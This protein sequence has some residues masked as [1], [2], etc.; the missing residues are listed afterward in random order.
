MVRMPEPKSANSER[1][2]PAAAVIVAAGQ[3]V[4]FGAAGPRK[5]YRLVLGIP[6]LEWAIRPFLDHPA[7]HQVVVVLPSAD[8][9]DPPEW[10][11][12]LPVNRVAGGERRSDSVRLGLDALDP[13]HERVL[14]HDGARPF[15]TAELIDRL[16][17]SISG[18]EAV[19]PGLRSTDT[20]KEV[21][22]DGIVRATV[23]RD[24]FWSV[25]TP[26]VFPLKTLRLLHERAL[27]AGV[28]TSDDAGLL[29]SNGHVVR[30][31]EGDPR[32]MKVTV[33]A[34]I[35]LAEQ[36]ARQLPSPRDGRPA[37]PP[38]PG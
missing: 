37:Q 33:P 35:P 11:A 7:I 10:L 17:G 2:V 16:L 20:V 6:V 19:I 12:A 13:G 23:D 32:N 25:Q 8:V 22:V 21:S 34:D 15:I 4:R 14:I 38:I 30:V 9:E 31:I 36:M 28:S 3:G 26:Q 5:Q 29:E 24:R 27:E 1:V 18:D